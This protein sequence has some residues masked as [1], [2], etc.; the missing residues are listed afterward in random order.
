[1]F[2]IE[3]KASLRAPVH[4][5]LLFHSPPSECSIGPLVSNVGVENLAH[6]GWKKCPPASPPRVPLRSDQFFLCVSRNKARDWERGR[7]R[8]VWLASNFERGRNREARWACPHFTT[9]ISWTTGGLSN[10]C[11]C[12]A[13]VKEGA[14]WT[15]ITCSSGFISCTQNRFHTKRM[16]CRG[17]R[18][19]QCGK[20]GYDSVNQPTQEITK[21]C[22]NGVGSNSN[23][24]LTEKTTK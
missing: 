22:I 1:M 11:S 21:F 2:H 18:S 24:S 17:R 5:S 19:V 7:V 13:L 8:E 15:S 12:E 6:E 4:A 14:S 23:L 20:I 16:S 10:A 3:S 9:W